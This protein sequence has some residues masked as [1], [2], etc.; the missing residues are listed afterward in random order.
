MKRGCQHCGEL[1]VG[2]AIGLQV[3]KTG[4]S[5]LIWLFAPSVLWKQKGFGSIRKKSMLE[6]NILRLEIEGVIV[7]DLESDSCLQFFASGGFLVTNR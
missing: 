3:K 7:R 2:N 1:I 5:C 6:A 4:S